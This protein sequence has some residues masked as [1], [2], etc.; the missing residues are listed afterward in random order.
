MKRPSWP[1]QIEQFSGILHVLKYSITLLV[2]TGAVM[3]GLIVTMN[4]LKLITWQLQLV[5]EQ[6]QSVQ[7]MLDKKVSV[8]K[9]TEEESFHG[10]AS[11]YDTIKDTS[12]SCGDATSKRFVWNNWP[13]DFELCNNST[14]SAYSYNKEID[15]RQWI[16][17]GNNWQE[18]QCFTQ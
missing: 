17:K 14:P 8:L 7:T 6:L 4:R 3:I 5:Q 12:L 16:C 11:V 1:L 10:N 9:A 18:Q 15:I 13:K 2:I